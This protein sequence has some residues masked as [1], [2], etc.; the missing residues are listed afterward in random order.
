[1]HHN[2]VG[3][4][5]DSLAK[6]GSMLGSAA[7]IVMDENVCMVEQALRLAEFYADESCGQ[8]TPCREGT[9]WQVKI[10][11]RMEH[12]KGRHGDVELL[13][14][15]SSN[16]LGNCLCPLGD[17]SAMMVNGFLKKFR[18]EFLM[19]VSAGRCTLKPAARTGI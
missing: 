4:D 12:G 6:A 14:R 1:I 2:D 5:F 16:I 18:N 17:A 7:V 15:V 8:C 11:K 19:H 10:L 13:E 9:I 3:M